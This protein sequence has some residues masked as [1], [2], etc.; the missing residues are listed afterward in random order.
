METRLENLSVDKTKGPSSAKNMV[1][2]L[3][4]G[5]INKESKYVYISKSNNFPNKYW[6]HIFFFRFLRLVFAC[7]DDEIIHLTLQRLPPQYISS[8]LEH[9]SS[10][11][12]KKTQKYVPL[13]QNKISS[14]LI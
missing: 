12:S 2:L 1:Q 8:L 4:Q 14:N 3:I 5:L 11:M 10:L 6:F 7:T 13:T 9:L